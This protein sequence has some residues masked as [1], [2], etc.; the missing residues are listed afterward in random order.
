MANDDLYT[1]CQLH[2]AATGMVDVAWIPAQF[3]RVGAKLTIGRLG[4]FTVTE[5]YASQPKV[6][7]DRTYDQ[8]RHFSENLA[9]HQ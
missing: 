1:Q 5:R 4:G 7:L 9:P 8:R 6:A 3:A 2:H